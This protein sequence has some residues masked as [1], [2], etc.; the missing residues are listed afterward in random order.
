MKHETPWYTEKEMG[1]AKDYWGDT[2]EWHF[3]ES[4]RRIKRPW[5]MFHVSQQAEFYFNQILF[6]SFFSTLPVIQT[7]S[8]VPAVSTLRWIWSAVAS[9]RH[10][11]LSHVDWQ[12]FLTIKVLGYSWSAYVGKK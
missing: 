1:E 8:L 7:N 4:R 11:V 6:F 9:T 5:W 2:S 3:S 10:S 12:H